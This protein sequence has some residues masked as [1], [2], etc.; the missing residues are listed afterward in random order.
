M[1]KKKLTKKEFSE[2][3]KD[4]VNDIDRKRYE[5]YHHKYSKGYSDSDGWRLV[6]IISITVVD[7]ECGISQT[8]ILKGIGNFNIYNFSEEEMTA[9]LYCK[10][11]LSGYDTIPDIVEKFTARDIEKNERFMYLGKEYIVIDNDFHSPTKNKNVVIAMLLIDDDPD[12][13]FFTFDK[14]IVVEVIGRY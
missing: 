5:I 3:A 10:L 7:K 2:W 9:V 1:S 8:G 14:D 6:D 11:S 13:K 4:I 12:G